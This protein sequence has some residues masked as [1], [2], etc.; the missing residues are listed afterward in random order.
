MPS[1]NI[2]ITAT[3]KTKGAFNSARRNV[4][5]LKGSVNLLKSA[6]VGY[7]SVAGARAFLDFTKRQ[8]D[9]ADAIGKTADRLGLSTDALQELSFGAER[10]VWQHRRSKWRCNGSREG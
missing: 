9:M 4:D 6:L 1:T 5:A 7:V 8:R 3:D 2:K 10:P